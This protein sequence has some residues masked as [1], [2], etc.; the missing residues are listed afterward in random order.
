MDFP[1]QAYWQMSCYKAPEQAQV[2][3]NQ[4]G[5]RP[6]GTQDK[7]NPIHS[8]CQLLW[9]QIRTQQGRQTSNE[10][11][12]ATLQRHGRLGGCKIHRNHT[13]LGLQEEINPPLHARL[14]QEGSH[15]IQSCQTVEA[16]VCTIPIH[17]TRLRRQKSIR[18]RT[19]PITATQQEREDVHSTG[20][21]EISVLRVGGQQHHTPCHQCYRITT[22]R[23]H[24]GN[25][26]PYQTTP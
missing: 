14:R 25:H 18:P 24:G 19:C 3:P 6:L 4:I 21:R 15:L 13:R 16:S 2:P 5:A 9:H 10:R 7:T 20:V 26:G 8:H 17:S 12:Q 11:N 23:T 22:S 1:N